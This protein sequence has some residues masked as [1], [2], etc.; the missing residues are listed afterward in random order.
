MQMKNLYILF[1]FFLFSSCKLSDD[2]PSELL[3]KDS[4]GEAY[5]SIFKNFKTQ[6]DEKYF[7]PTKKEIQLAEILLIKELN[8]TKSQL[9]KEYDFFNETE[10]PLSLNQYK[11][12]YYPSITKNNEKRIY[13][14]GVCKELLYMYP[15]WDKKEIHTAGGGN[16]FFRGEINLSLK[17]ITALSV[18]AP[19]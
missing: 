13:F 10:T 16:C 6:K 3:I 12:Q 8:K 18:N 2:K 5:I 17:K 15:N 19:I 4:K 11:R 14:L 7:H 9:V 1:C